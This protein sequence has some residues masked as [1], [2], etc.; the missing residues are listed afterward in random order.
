[1]CFKITSRNIKVYTVRQIF[2]NVCDA[3]GWQS[4]FFSAIHSKFKQDDELCKSCVVHHINLSQFRNQKV[5]DRTTCGNG[6][7]FLARLHDAHFSLIGALHLVSNFFGGLLGVCKHIDERRVIEQVATAV[8]KAEQQVIFKFFDLLLI[9]IHLLKQLLALLLQ[10]GLLLGNN[11]TKQLI[12]KTFHCDSKVD[13]GD[14]GAEFGCVMRVGQ[15]RRHKQLECFCIVKF[16]VCKSNLPTFALLDNHLL[17]NW[18]HQ[19]I[20]VLFNVFNQQR[21]SKRE[22]IFQVEPKHF[23][24]KTDD[25]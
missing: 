17:K 21:L 10:L 15:T 13:D 8:C 12:F 7:I 18:F 19:W 9:A 2:N 24:R 1:M 4:R 23:V 11:T 16:F 6:P 3:F 14:L 5:N 20:N 22:C 25:F